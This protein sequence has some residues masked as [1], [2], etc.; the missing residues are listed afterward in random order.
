MADAV[1][2]ERT[3]AWIDKELVRVAKATAEIEGKG[4]AGADVIEQELRGPLMKR[5][6]KAINREHAELGEAGA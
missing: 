5:Y 3:T 2:V 4:E 1:K 6:R